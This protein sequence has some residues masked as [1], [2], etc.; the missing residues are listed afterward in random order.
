MGERTAVGS[1]AEASKKVPTL[2]KGD[3]SNDIALGLTI[4]VSTVSIDRLGHG[5]D[6][7]GLTQRL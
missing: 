5:C 2:I 3:N 6:L 1:L 7:W 4:L